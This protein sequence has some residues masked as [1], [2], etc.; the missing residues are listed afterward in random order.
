M[1]TQAETPDRNE[2]EQF[3]TALTRVGSAWA[4]YGLNVA[5]A[6]VETSARTLDLT[7]TALG[8]LAERV[9]R[10]EVPESKETV[11]DTTAEPRS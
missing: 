4:R 6:S 2:Y 1:N 11:V 8:A 9:S 5:R 3:A 7:A 10:I